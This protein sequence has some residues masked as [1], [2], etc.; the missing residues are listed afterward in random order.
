MPFL[1]NTPARLLSGISTSNIRCPFSTTLIIRHLAK[2]YSTS[3]NL[4]RAK[5]TQLKLP[6]NSNK[7]KKIS[8]LLQKVPTIAPSFADPSEFEAFQKLKS[9]IESSAT[10]PTSSLNK[11]TFLDFLTLADLNKKLFYY[12]NHVNDVNDS[13]W[14]IVLKETDL[15][16]PTLPLLDVASSRENFEV[17]TVSDDYKMI[18]ILQKAFKMIQNKVQSEKAIKSNQQ[19]LSNKFINNPVAWFPEARMMKRKIIMHVGPTNSGK[20]FNALQRL[21]NCERDGYYAG[22]LRLLAREIYERFKSE[23][24]RCNFLTGEEIIQDLDDIGNPANLTSGTVEMVPLNREFECVVLD[25]IQ[26]MNDSQRGWAWSNIVLGCR[27]KELHLC[28]EQTAVPIIENLV[29]QTGDSLEIVEYKRL[30]KLKCEEATVKTK[31]FFQKSLLKGDCLIAFSKKTI[32]KLKLQIEKTTT[33][34]VAV[35]YGSL[36][37]ETRLQQAKLF[38]EGHYDVLVASDAVGMGLNLSIKR[39][40]FTSSEK[41][42]GEKMIPLTISNI[43]QIGGRAGRYK[44]DSDGPSVGYV[45]ATR[46]DILE[47]VKEGLQAPVIPLKTMIVWPP[48]HIIYKMIEDIEKLDNADLVTLLTSLSESLQ[49]STNKLFQLTDLSNRIESIQII[50]P[51]S[52]L[53]FQD[54]LV[55]SNAPCKFHR[56]TVKSAFYNF[57]LTIAKQQTC[58]ITNFDFLPF[59]LIDLKY[60]NNDEVGSLEVYEDL[61]QTL[62]LYSW[63][64]NRWPNYLVGVDTAKTLRDMCELIIFYKLENLEKNPYDRFIG[65]PQNRAR[66]ASERPATGIK[67]RGGYEKR[68]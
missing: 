22:P 35:I 24:T 61:H 51:I 12:L 60:L 67:P 65:K 47:S 28:G 11:P 64:S 49:K 13:Q 25:E 2:S 50:Q 17:N 53:S 40:V 63:L 55:L 39:I 26:M 33:F 42:D 59:R 8:E 68:F 21:K 38:N 30:G 37:P 44:S 54:R 31:N 6:E 52:G 56:P 57:C 41:F 15:S 4:A 14:K 32:M 5:D 20:T 43:K 9:I 19:S 10:T 1:R 34:K 45:A 58:T 16:T 3:G 23:N 66:F 46:A 18:Y 27:A 29:K 48:D 36:P 62:Q 7:A